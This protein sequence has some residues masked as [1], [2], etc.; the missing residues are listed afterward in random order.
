LI[1]E[2]STSFN[3]RG[4]PVPRVASEVS[5][6]TAAQLHHLAAR[7]RAASADTHDQ[8][9]SFGDLLDASAS[10]PPPPPDR[11]DPAPKSTGG[12]AASSDTSSDPPPASTD[13]GTN[14]TDPSG[15]AATSDGTEPAKTDVAAKTDAS[16]TDASTG[17]APDG[18]AATDDTEPTKADA[19]D[20]LVTVA[21]ADA[22]VPASAP[23]PTAA[24]IALDAPL[25]AP[26]KPTGDGSVPGATDAPAA[27][28]TPPAALNDADDTPADAKA[29][30]ASAGASN[31]DGLKT[32]VPKSSSPKSDALKSDA[33]TTDPLK[34]DGPK[35]DG[36]TS[37][38]SKSAAADDGSAP[39]TTPKAGTLAAQAAAKANG[40]KDGT[41]D[42]KGSQTTTDATATTDAGT[43]KSESK[44]DPADTTETGEAKA[45]AAHRGE[46]APAEAA[47]Q[48]KSDR[49]RVKAA[50]G[51]TEGTTSD[52]F[53][54]QMP[55]TASGGASTIGAK[56]FVEAMQVALSTGD[57]SAASAASAQTPATNTALVPLAG[58]AVEI[59]ARADAGSNR[60][61]IRLDPPELGRIDV[62][63]TVDGSGNVSSRLVVER[64]DTL[65][66]LVR[67][68]T[69]LQR[70]LQ[71]A[72]LNT[73]GGMQFQLADQGFAS[74]QGFAWQNDFT[75][76]KP[77]LNTAA[78]ET[79]PAAAV[80]GYGA[81]ASR[82]GG[83]DIR[84]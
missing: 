59:A 14:G 17:A 20:P 16:K 6:S 19:T 34:A 44:A 75:S 3:L 4:Q 27:P 74:R 36:S 73:G 77:A 9:S 70:T 15:A 51:Q 66:L 80:Q 24:A 23:A 48:G 2:A 69:Q 57:A 71:D 58:L 61:E 64:S 68:A 33:L 52:S 40:G 49:S 31:T 81:S 79:V 42:S 41:T 1:A 37:N 55:G 13:S 56:P 7:S 39:V 35:S 28:P 76:P 26:P 12:T 45:A 60:F 72:G 82:G 30:D 83:L 84:V 46:G 10:P 25:A 22:T 38:A 78:T 47:Q 65:N 8:G 29:S 21:T 67:D 62:Q 53:A 54:N 32:E 18:G 11:R 43:A 50:G 5:V 63:L